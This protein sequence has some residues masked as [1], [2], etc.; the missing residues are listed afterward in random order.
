MGKSMMLG[1]AL[2][3]A[4]LTLASPAGA[5]PGWSRDSQSAEQLRRLDIML[6][7]TSLRCRRTSSDFSADYD[8]FA[9]NHLSTLNDA[10]SRLR[11]TYARGRSARAQNRAIDTISTS[12]AN[13]YG[14]GHPWL[15][16]EELASVTRNLAA[17][18]NLDAML[19]AADELLAERPPAQASQ[20]A[21]Y[22]AR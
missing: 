19:A 1:C 8:R 13:R 3:T 15:G 5:T 9:S 21:L 11:D 12:M 17:E 4:A 7:V 22:T 18:R 16:C 2:A 6:M 10:T 20:L 14:L